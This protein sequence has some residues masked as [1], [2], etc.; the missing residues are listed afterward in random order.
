MVNDERTFLAK[1]HL[2]LRARKW[3]LAWNEKYKCVNIFTRW[4]ISG[5]CWAGFFLGGNSTHCVTGFILSL[6]LFLNMKF[7]T[8][9][10]TCMGSDVPH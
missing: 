10:L 4:N 9:I 6:F 2:A 7:P 8:R 1:S 3:F 5:S